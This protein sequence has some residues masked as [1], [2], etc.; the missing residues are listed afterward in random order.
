MNASFIQKIYMGFN[1]IGAT[2]ANIKNMLKAIEVTNMLCLC[3]IKINRV[4]TK[5]AIPIVMPNF[6]K[7][8][9]S[10]FNFSILLI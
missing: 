4:I 5:K 1:K 7:V 9:L 2:K 8:F 10:K 6:F 3:L